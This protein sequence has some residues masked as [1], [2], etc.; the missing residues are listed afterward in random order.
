MRFLAQQWGCPLQEDRACDEHDCHL[1]ATPTVSPTAQPTQRP[2][3]PT[4]QP[5]QH[6]ALLPTIVPWL[7]KFKHTYAIPTGEPT[8]APTLPTMSPT[9][10]THSPTAP[11]LSPTSV[12][13][14]RL[15]ANRVENKGGK[16][17]PFEAGEAL[18]RLNSPHTATEVQNEVFETSTPTMWPTDLFE[19]KFISG[20]DAPTAVPTAIPT[21]TC[22]D[23]FRPRWWAD[24]LI[25]DDGQR[26]SNAPEGLWS[27]K[28]QKARELRLQP[29][30]G[31]IDQAKNGLID[32]AGYAGPQAPLIGPQAP[33]EW[34]WDVLC[35]EQASLGRC[36]EPFMRPPHCDISCGRCKPLE[37]FLPSKPIAYDPLIGASSRNPTAEHPPVGGTNNTVYNTHWTGMDVVS[38]HTESHIATTG[39]AG[40][41][42]DLAL[43]FPA[44]G[45]IAFPWS[46]WSGCSQPCKSGVQRRTRRV[47]WQGGLNGGVGA[48]A[49]PTSSPS[50]PSAPS[51]RCDH[52]GYATVEVRTCNQEPCSSPSCA[53]LDTFFEHFFTDCPTLSSE[54]A[55]ASTAS[56]HG[57]TS[58]QQQHH[59]ALL[60]QK[61]RQQMST[62]KR[63]LRV[64]ELMAAMKGLAGELNA[65]LRTIQEGECPS[66]IERACT[67]TSCL[68]HPSDSTHPLSPHTPPSPQDP[69]DWSRWSACSQPCESGVQTRTGWKR[70]APEDDADPLLARWDSVNG[71]HDNTLN[72]NT[73][74]IKVQDVRNCN[75]VP[76]RKSTSHFL[77]IPHS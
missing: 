14:F 60:E 29:K 15:W 7:T 65:L 2:S 45:C 54:A 62:Q 61:L 59:A 73:S 31:L 68:P 49:S 6:P 22:T 21:F 16:L 27:S 72:K 57:G 24:S 28:L 52:L 55:C 66:M 42:S 12:P 39:R 53:K 56:A 74:Q 19:H 8:N 40:I 48:T 70:E 17:T 32:Q 38:A 9:T 20:T 18:Q 50:T 11:T 63:R 77:M 34:V 75:T 5:T 23:T 41:D 25:D 33:A 64:G 76:C 58:S 44:V 26:E 47:I 71:H 36:D 10:P 30:N 46:A 1:T 35:A 37:K 3:L 13:S 43:R 69:V 4:A 67:P 51:S